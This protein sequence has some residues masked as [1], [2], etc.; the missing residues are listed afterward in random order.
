MTYEERLERDLTR[1]RQK[2]AGMSVLLGEALENAVTALV[3]RDH[4]LAYAIILEDNCINRGF[5]EIN[6][7]CYGFV[8]RHLPSAGH[9][10]RISSILRLNIEMERI[11]DY[12]V[13]ICRE[14]VQFSKPYNKS[15]LRDIE[16]MANESLHILHLAFKAFNEDNAELAENTMGLSDRANLTFINAYQNLTKAK[17]LSKWSLRELLGLFVVYYEFERISDQAKNICEATLFAV[18]GLPKKQKIFHILFLDAENNCQSLMA[19]FF[20]K[21]AFPESGRYFSAGLKPA[22]KLDPQFV[23]F[24]DRCGFEMTGMKPK[25][26]DKIAKLDDFDIIVSLQGPIKSH[27]SKVPFHTSILEWDVAPLLSEIAEDQIEEHLSNLHKTI[28]VNIRILMETLC[29]EEEFED[30]E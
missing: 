23:S 29:V 11:G 30:G 27:I 20:A 24:M 22:E 28:L 8:A 14:A 16:Q 15:V 5:E 2:M 26:M 12:A 13:T 18:K 7:L 9:L 6:Q 21:K 4:K 10:R 19:E 17:K 3:K 25:S 1:I